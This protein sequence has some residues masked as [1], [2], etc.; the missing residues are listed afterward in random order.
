LI[1]SHRH[2]YLFV[3]LP[4]TGSTAIRQELRDLY[5]GEPILHKHATYD[6]FLRVATPDEKTY[7]VFSGIRNPLDDAVSQYF[8]L[9]TDHN[10]RMTNP[11]RAPKSKPI[12]NRVVDGYIFRYLRRT[13]A[14]FPTY[15]M[16]FHL[17]P[18]D[19]WS[20][21]SHDRFDFVIR[22]ESLAY[23]FAEALRRIGIDPKRDLPQVNP[24]AARARTWH[25]YYPPHTRARARRVFG[26]FMERWG[27]EFPQE[28]NVGSTTA[29]DRAQYK[30]F[31]FIAGLYWRHGRRLGTHGRRTL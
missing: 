27:Y 19:R 20:S 12:L 17:L 4:R 29:P 24:T 5:D 14:D 8:K 23:D 18:Y 21:L 9:K 28:W 31:S 3:E 16:R 13:N 15:F 7:F 6:E 26:P 22:F 11:R 2:R 30:V 10:E 25:D 1:V